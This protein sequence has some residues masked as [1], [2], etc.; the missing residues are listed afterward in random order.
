M[1]ALEGGYEGMRLWRWRGDISVVSASVDDDDDNNFLFLNVDAVGEEQ[2]ERGL[3]M[4]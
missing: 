1:R 4:L 2:H 3:R